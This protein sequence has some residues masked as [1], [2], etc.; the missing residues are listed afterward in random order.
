MLHRFC[1]FG[2]AKPFSGFPEGCQEESVPPLLLALVSVIL[3]GPNMKKQVAGTNHAAVSAAQIL[4]FNSIK[5]NKHVA[6][7]H[8]PVSGTVLNRRPHFQ[9]T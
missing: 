4:K 3:E 1:M 2:E 8:P 5:H 9:Y 6:P 7:N